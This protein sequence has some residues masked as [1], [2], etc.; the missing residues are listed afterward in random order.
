MD[1]PDTFDSAAFRRDPYGT[2]AWLRE[3]RP[4]HEVQPGHYALTRYDDV[5]QALLD[6]AVYSSGIDTLVQQEWMTPDMRG[7]LF[8]LSMAPP[9]HGAHRKIVQPPF[10]K[11]AVD[12]LAHR[13]V[14]IAN[15][16]L[17]SAP[18]GTAIEFVGA[19]AYPLVGEVI[20]HILGTGQDVATLR[21]RYA[22]R[23]KVTNATPTAAELQLL[24]SAIL[25]QRA[26]F[27]E[28]IAARRAAPRDD[29]LSVLVQAQVDG[30]P[31]SGDELQGALDLL[32]SAG[33]H[34]T[35]Q[36]IVNAALHFA[37]APGLFES[38]RADRSLIPRYVDELLRL[39]SPTHF[40]LR[41]A[42][43][44]IDLHGVHIPAGSLVSLV[45]ASANRDRA[46]FADGDAMNLQADHGH[47]L[48]FG[49]GIHRCLGQL[50]AKL[51]I[52]TAIA[53]LAS[54]YTSIDCLADVEWQV[55]LTTRTLG[56]LHLRLN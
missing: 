6:P 43:V 8:I 54:H 15:R 12:A 55:T 44:P 29:L 25:D 16:H 37:Q 23:E 18:R 14:E 35:S 22:V 49:H 56:Q 1:A 46:H 4:V 24:R 7:S 40:I 41:K 30:A 3:H 28:L 36:A 13:V 38:L 32:L 42:A 17:T 51:E 19:M 52:E 45:V 31:L 11:A 34:T 33:F 9:R 20:N 47:H 39:K 48:S 53:A 26:E 27:A 10:A 2:Y 5:K 50:L 21:R